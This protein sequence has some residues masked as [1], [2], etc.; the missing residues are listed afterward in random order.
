[1][2]GVDVYGVSAH[3]F[4]KC[5]AA[6]FV[7]AISIPF[8]VVVA[9]LRGG[10]VVRV[11]VAV[12]AV[13]AAV[14]VSAVPGRVPVVRAAVID[15]CGTMPAAVPTAVSPGATTTAHHGPDGDACTETDDSRGSH[16]ARA[17][18][19]NHVGCAIN[20]CWVIDGNVDNL[21]I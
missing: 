13:I 10:S 12:A 18:I 8:V 2:I 4:V 3:V 16:I 7:V 6:G 5:V 15:H 21:R 1:M 11:V 19:G 17:V 20:H 14:V 9:V